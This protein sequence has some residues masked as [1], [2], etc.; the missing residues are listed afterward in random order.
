[1]APTN[2]KLHSSREI[3]LRPTDR[4]IPPPHPETHH[5]LSTA[6][7]FVTILS[8][9]LSRRWGEERTILIYVLINHSSL[10]S[11]PLASLPSESPDVARRPPLRSDCP[12]VLS[13]AKIAQWLCIFIT[14]CLCVAEAR[15]MH[16]VFL[17][18]RNSVGARL[19]RG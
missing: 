12:Y 13:G 1:M 2:S 18:L 8:S 16:A 15:T 17:L 5:Y 9:Q 11:P 7:H 3:C 14:P 6:T 4:V 19:R 10:S